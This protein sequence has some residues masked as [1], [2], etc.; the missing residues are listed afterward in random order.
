MACSMPCLQL[1]I[2]F[3]LRVL[4]LFIWCGVSCGTVAELFWLTLWLSSGEALVFTDSRNHVITTTISTVIMIVVVVDVGV[5]CIPREIHHCDVAHTGSRSN[6]GTCFIGR[7]HLVMLHTS[8]ECCTH[9]VMLHTSHEY[10]NTSLVG[11]TSCD[12]AHTGIGSNSGLASLVGR[13]CWQ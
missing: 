5:C 8:R 1:R 12:V 3:C 6:P 9:H 4:S 7:Q 13:H 11:Q 2:T 10:L